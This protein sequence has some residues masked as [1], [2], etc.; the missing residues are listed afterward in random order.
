[1]R[2]LRE[3]E[4]VKLMFPSFDEEKRA[5]PQRA[6]TCTGA[7]LF[8]DPMFR[9]GQ[10]V[11]RNSWPFIEQEG[12]LTYGSGGDRLKIVWLRTHTYADGTAGGPLAVI[13]S[14]ERFAELFAI[15]ALRSQSER[16]K[17]GTA[18]M[19]GDFLVTAENDGCTGRK[20][21]TACQTVMSVFLPRRGQLGTV[22]DIPV[23]RIAYSGKAERGAMG[24]LEY[25]LTSVPEFRADAIRFVEQVRVK[26]DAGRD[27]RKA[28]HERIFTIDDK[29]KATASGPSL[30]DQVVKSDDAPGDA[31]RPRDTSDAKAPRSR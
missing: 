14:G 26:D 21:G 6:E 15:G 30:W 1:M 24:V 27:L 9:D 28:E 11:R 25:H 22:V 19:G 4:V 13:R 29:G 31:P 18:R 16:T 20:A 23:E 3:P 5:L 7:A 2:K 12:D 17:L 8:D 10:L